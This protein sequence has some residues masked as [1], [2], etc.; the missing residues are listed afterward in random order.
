MKKINLP[1]KISGG[2]D[3]WKIP[4]S[5]SQIREWDVT[6]QG[7]QSLMKAEPSYCKATATRSMHCLFLSLSP[8]GSLWHFTSSAAFVNFIDFST[9]QVS[10]C[11]SV[12]WIL[13]GLELR[14]RRHGVLK[15]QL[16]WWRLKQ[17]LTVWV[18][19]T[20]PAGHWVAES[21][22]EKYLLCSDKVLL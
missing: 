22:A 19:P 15:G 11:V 1:C 17:S 6:C 18:S 4:G 5:L 16:L 21:S 13:T 2:H 14:H 9:S 10:S 20:P 3:F 7:F 12:V 8:D